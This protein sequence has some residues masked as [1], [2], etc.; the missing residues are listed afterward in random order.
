MP[1]S[2]EGFDSLSEELTR[3]SALFQDVEKEY[4]RVYGYRKNRGSRFNVV[5]SIL[6]DM[7]DSTST[8]VRSIGEELK[9]CKI[10]YALEDMTMDGIVAK[11]AEISNGVKGFVKD[12][13]IRKYTRKWMSKYWPL[14]IWDESAFNDAPVF[15][16]VRNMVRT[17]A[18]N[19]CRFPLTEKAHNG[20]GSAYMYWYIDYGDVEET[21]MTDDGKRAPNPMSFLWNLNQHPLVR[22][23]GMRFYVPSVSQVQEIHKNGEKYGLFDVKWTE[24]AKTSDGY[25]ILVDENGKVETW[26]SVADRKEVESKTSSPSSSSSHGRLRYFAR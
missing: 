5:G 20:S 3:Q 15:F 17:P 18:G 21:H 19:A 6:D 4:K 1:G 2:L 10:R 26:Y 7:M 16:L 8:L 24:W 14:V 11:D 12:L 25:F 13:P 9:N 22:E 23:S